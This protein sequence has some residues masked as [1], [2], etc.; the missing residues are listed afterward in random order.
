M[1]QFLELLFSLL[2]KKLDFK[3]RGGWTTYVFD[4]RASLAGCFLFSFFPQLGYLVGFLYGNLKADT[5][6]GLLAFPHK[7]AHICPD[8]KN[9]D[10]HLSWRKEL[11]LLWKT[12]P[13]GISFL[14]SSSFRLRQP[15]VLTKRIATTPKPDEKNCDYSEKRF[16]KEFLFCFHRRSAS[17]DRKQTPETRHSNHKSEPEI[18]TWH[19]NMKQ[20]SG[21]QS[22]SIKIKHKSEI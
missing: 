15:K 1:G 18:R 21:M 4:H 8:E 19:V 6:G 13:Q 16:R 14:F 2:R 17:G 20:K 12:V 3:K 7:F 10:Y 11:R 9:C 5:G 22:W